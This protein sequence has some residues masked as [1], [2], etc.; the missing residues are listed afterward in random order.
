MDREKAKRLLNKKSWTGKEVGKAYLY[1]LSEQTKAK[2]EK[3]EFEAPFTRE[4]LDKMEQSVT[5][6][7]QY[8]VFRAYASLYGSLVDSSNMAE[9]QIQQMYNGFYRYL[10]TLKDCIQADDALRVVQNYPLIMTNIQYDRIKT[11]LVKERR[12]IKTSFFDTVIKYVEKATLN[13][14]AIPENI[15]SAIE[16]TKNQICTNRRVTDNYNTHNY[17]GAFQESIK[18]IERLKQKQKESFL[19]THRLTINDKK[20]SKDN[21]FTEYNNTGLLELER[22][23]FEGIEGIEKTCKEVGIDIQKS[24]CSAQDVLD[25]LE[26]LVNNTYHFKSDKGDN[27]DKEIKRIVSELVGGEIANTLLCTTNNVRDG[28]DESDACDGGNVLDTQDV[29]KLSKFDVL[30]QPDLLR[31]YEGT[32]IKEFVGDYPVLYRTVAEELVRILPKAVGMSEEECVLPNFTY[33]E[34][35]NTGIRIFDDF[36]NVSDGDVLDYYCKKDCK[37]SN[38]N[39]TIRTFSGLAIIKDDTVK[40]SQIAKN[41]D[42]IENQSNPY[43][44]LESIDSII[45]SERRLNELRHYKEYLIEPALR[46]IYAFNTLVDCIA[47][48]YDVCFIDVLKKDMYFIESQI[49]GFNC[50]LYNFY[51]NV[52]GSTE[53]KNRKRRLIKQIFRPIVTDLLIPDK[54][55]IK[56]MKQK[57]VSTYGKSSAVGMLK[58]LH[59]LTL[60]LISNTEGASYV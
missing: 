54:H 21:S 59:E 28:S 49:N 53:E 40:E 50:L 36:L 2:K 55:K 56:A 11:K 3:V 46:Y 35:Q 45:E 23:Y 30:V 20:E 27:Y 41:G 43:F 38:Q 19:A 16:D 24:V 47:E 58:D 7:E 12:A 37:T 22:L 52:F 1:S 6:Q 57:L 60:E 13:L 10:Y 5:V 25:F 34:L 8:V 9:G 26:K 39:G 44:M 17:N 15:R 29:P 48:A 33:D 32:F 4:D 31:L 51:S 42:F 14:E 18:N